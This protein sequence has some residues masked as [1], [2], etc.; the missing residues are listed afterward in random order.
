LPLQPHSQVAEIGFGGGGLLFRISEA[1]V[2][3]SVTGID[4]SPAVVA[5]A[6]ARV[7]RVAGEFQILLRV[8][9]VDHLPLS[10]NELDLAVSV[11]TI[12]F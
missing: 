5:R 11:N 10:D 8:G 9:T 7:S 1:L 2:T 3:G 6:K 4:P 12:Y